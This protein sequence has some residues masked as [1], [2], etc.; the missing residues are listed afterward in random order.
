MRQAGQVRD[1]ANALTIVSWA[2]G[3]LAFV[4]LL[5]AAL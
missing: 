5:V 3:F 1:A 4:N 2:L